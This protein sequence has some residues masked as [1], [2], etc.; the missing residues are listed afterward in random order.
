MPTYKYDNAPQ[1]MYCG[2]KK[3]QKTN[4]GHLIDSCDG[5][6]LKKCDDGYEFYDYVG[7]VED[8]LCSL[9]TTFDDGKV[10]R[11]ARIPASDKYWNPLPTKMGGNVGKWHEYDINA[12]FSCCTNSE[13]NVDDKS[14][15]GT[16][17]W[18]GSGSKP[19][20]CTAV[21]NKFCKNG[22]NI[23]NP[24]CKAI[25]SKTPELQTILKTKCP[26][27]KG[28]KGNG[29]WDDVCACYYG[30]PVYDKLAKIVEKEWE[31]PEGGITRIPEC[32][33]PRCA[34]SE[35]KDETI[36]K[37]PCPDTSFTKCVQNANFVISDSTIGDVKF[38]SECTI[39][40]KKWERA[41]NLVV[42]DSSD[43]PVK[44]DTNAEDIDDI[45]D[46]VPS[47]GMDDTT[48]IILIIIVIVLVALG[49]YWAVSGDDDDDQMMFVDDQYQSEPYGSYY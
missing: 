39:G 16:F 49:L 26:E 6:D 30:F 46:K 18:E 31:G 15:C 41:K 27:K 10:V 20:A 9:N 38:K 36:D 8:S 25:I 2:K 40:E 7:S 44:K 1:Y 29:A 19:N 34:A 37:K 4:D 28:K 47:D 3:C 35:Y 45:D 21:L 17:L 24:H 5:D 43:A 11:C 22:D 13:F 14:N 23:L 42:D 48:K 33:D 12:A 32:I